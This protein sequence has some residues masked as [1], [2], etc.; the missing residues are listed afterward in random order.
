MMSPMEA[1]AWRFAKTVATGMRVPLTLPG[2]LSMPGI[3]T[4]QSTAIAQTRI[5]LTKANKKRYNMIDIG[6]FL[7]RPGGLFGDLC[8]ENRRISPLFSLPGV[9]AGHE[10]LTN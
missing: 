10:C 2:I 4:N 9:S 8:L 3:S 1:P 7:A 5:F 6:I